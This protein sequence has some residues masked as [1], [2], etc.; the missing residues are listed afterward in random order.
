MVVNE[1]SRTLPDLLRARSHASTAGLNFLDADGDVFQS[2]SYAQLFAES[3]EYAARLASIVKTDGSDVVITHFSDHASHIRIF[4][5]CCLGQC[6]PRWQFFLSL[7]LLILSWNPSL[8]NS[9]TSPRPESSSPALRTSSAAFQRP[10]VYLDRR[11]NWLCPQPCSNI[12]DF[13][14]FTSYRRRH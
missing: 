12:E 7:M 3:Q 4:W 1:T 10:Y 5:A 2:L 6:P 11:Y 13:V 14:H 9:S 8:P